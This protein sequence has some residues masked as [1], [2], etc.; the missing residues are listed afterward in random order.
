MTGPHAR[1]A[2]VRQGASAPV[3][4]LV[5]AHGRG[6]DAHDILA[7]GRSI[8]PDD[9][10][11]IAPQAAGNSWWPVSFL[12]PMTQLEPWLGSA[13]DAMDRAV[14]ALRAE[15]LAPAQ[16][17]LAGFSQGAC[18]AL[19]YAARHG[20]PWRAVVALSGALVGAADGAGQPDAALYGHSPKSL[21]YDTRLSGVPVLMACHDRD[22]HIPR[23]RIM[24]SVDTLRA[25]GSK[26]ELRTHPGTGHGAGPGDLDA[27][28]EM[29]RRDARSV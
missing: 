4:G 1:A 7:L 28:R 12:A 11:L 16:I 13:L 29:L 9:W 24:A 3:A 20:G 27:A 6:A 18:L 21:D 2:L 8:A 23:A 19:E 22:P 26:V 25:L 15:G 17:A 5:L 14:A 10:A